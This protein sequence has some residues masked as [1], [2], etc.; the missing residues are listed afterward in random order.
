MIEEKNYLVKQTSPMK[1]K[2]DMITDYWFSP[3][4]GYKYYVQSSA[5]I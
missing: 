2:L 4:T 1:I 3:L 5:N